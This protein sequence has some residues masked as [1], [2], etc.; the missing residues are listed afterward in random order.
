MAGANVGCALARAPH[1]A[2]ASPCPSLL[3]SCAQRLRWLR[4]PYAV[5]CLLL[6]LRSAA[7]ARAGDD[8][9]GSLVL[10]S[11]HRP[12]RAV[13]VDWGA[14]N[15]DSLTAMVAHVKTPTTK[16]ALHSHFDVAYAFE[17]RPVYNALWRDIV[18]RST[19]PVVNFYNYAVWT[20]NTTL[21]FSD[22]DL[23]SSGVRTADNSKD[24]EKKPSLKVAAMD[25]DAWL[26]AHV[27]PEDDVT[28][29][30]DIELAEARR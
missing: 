28:V 17:A 5:C 10:L 20:E 21:T 6:L 12:G 23:S 30:V 13:L 18:A 8:A 16:N 1:A 25:A 19:A 27:A 3:F 9:T 7:G 26:R 29:K 14:R 11:P 22:N 4:A 24:F 2:R 15:G